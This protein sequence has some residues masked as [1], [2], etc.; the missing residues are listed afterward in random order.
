M[1]LILNTHSFVHVVVLLLSLHQVP[2]YELTVK[3]SNMPPSR[4]LL[5]VNSAPV[6][7]S[8]NLWKKWYTT[9]HLPDLVKNGVGETGTFYQ[10]VPNSITGQLPSSDRPFLAIYDTTF[11]SPITTPNF[12]QC[13]TT[14]QLFTE[15]GAP[16]E[17]GKN[18]NADARVYE[19]IQ[20]YDPHS[21]GHKPSPAMMTVEV[22]TPHPDDL[23]KWLREELLPVYSKLPG[24]R[25][26]SLFY[27]VLP[28]S[29]FSLSRRISSAP[30][31]IHALN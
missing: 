8:H 21:H 11:A 13:R 9:E 14:S 25:P 1:R 31:V 5:H 19:F 23:D 26:L 16:E 18:I 29:S 12:L 20:D 7:V 10:E 3:S 4:Y 22:S 24:V 30:F 6:S 28:M 17:I 27:L 15:E 2:F